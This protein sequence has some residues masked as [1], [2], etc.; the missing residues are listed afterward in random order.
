[1]TEWKKAWRNCGKTRQVAK[2]KKR[3]KRLNHRLNRLAAK[4]LQKDIVRLDGWAVS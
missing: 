3:L 4:A 2:G 1:M